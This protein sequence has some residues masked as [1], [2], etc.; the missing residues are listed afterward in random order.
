LAVEADS[1]EEM[2][3]AAVAE[4]GLSSRPA[5]GEDVQG[6]SARGRGRPS[7]LDRDR[8]IREALALLNEVSVDGFSMGMLAKRLSAGVMTLYS[9]FP[10]RDALL[11][12]VADEIYSRFEYPSKSS[13]WQDEIRD[14][15]WATVRLFERY[16]VAMT[17]S[18][19]DGHASPGW[20]RTWIPVVELIKAQ[21]LEGPRLAFAVRWFT[22]S[23]LGFITS[24]PPPPMQ[25]V[26]RTTAHVDVLTPHEATLLQDLQLDLIEVDH[27][28]SL[29]YGFTHIIA[30]L[31]RI[32]VEAI[33]EPAPLRL[34][35]TT[36][37]E[38]EALP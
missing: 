1:R 15:M 21:G 3:P 28:A 4:H 16:P 13:C 7:R 26:G 36:D 11:I 35:K 6:K 27:S 10:S 9:Y 14:W 29:T 2:R 19:W 23:S 12:A 24:Q 31:E 17:L 34:F 22:T 5:P 38:L 37:G 33:G 8:I 25:R 20:L 32:I 18:L 30:G